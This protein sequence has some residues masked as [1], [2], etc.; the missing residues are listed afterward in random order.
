MNK[1]LPGAFKVVVLSEVTDGTQVTVRAGNDENLCADLR[2]ATAVLKNQVAKFN[3]LRFVGRSGRGKS[4]NLTITVQSSPVQVA[5]YLKAIKVTVDGPREPRSK[6]RQQQQCRAFVFGQRP[7]LD[8]L[9]D[10]D[11]F[12]R[13]AEP[14]LTFKVPQP[15]PPPPTLSETGIGTGG[16]L[17]LSPGGTMGGEGGNWATPFPHHHS[18]HHH[19]PHPHLHPH[20][21]SPPSPSPYY[22]APTDYHP[23]SASPLIDP[24]HYLPTA[25]LSEH[26]ATE[27]AHGGSAFSKPGEY[28]GCNAMDPFNK[29]GDSSSKSLLYTADPGTGCNGMQAGSTTPGFVPQTPATTATTTSAFLGHSYYGAPSTNSY[30]NPSPMLQSSF[31]YP[32]LYSFNQIPPTPVTEVK[33]EPLDGNLSQGLST[34]LQ[35]EN[36]SE[37]SASNQP[38]DSA[39][40]LQHVSPYETTSTSTR[41][42]SSP[43]APVWRPY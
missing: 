25:G 29:N 10:L 19:H 34:M 41:T 16:G 6:T 33:A 4:L 15:P 35:Q 23:S 24:V 5:T 31:L 30:L 36:P 43:D 2:N 9:R 39:S 28:P 7:F 27:F 20:Q 18:H 17:G 40:S 22:P 37:E 26:C 38:S 11:P 13:K 32:H 8:P 21:M 12:R 42:E 3:D 14:S 1:T